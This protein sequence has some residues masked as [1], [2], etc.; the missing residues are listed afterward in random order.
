MKA[1]IDCWLSMFLFSVFLRLVLGNIPKNKEHMFNAVLENSKLL[2]KG[3]SQP[4]IFNQALK[5]LTKILILA[6]F[7]GI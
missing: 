5:I 1:Q 6:K 4:P 7:D 2:N 3:T